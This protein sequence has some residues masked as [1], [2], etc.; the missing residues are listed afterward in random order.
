MAMSVRI[1]AAAS[2]LTLGVTVGACGSADESDTSSDGGQP[3]SESHIPSDLTL[4]GSDYSYTVDAGCGERAGLV[5]MYRIRVVD[6]EVAHVW[7]LSGG[8]GQV[9]LTDV[10]TIDQLVEEAESAE[11]EGADQVTVTTSPQG[12]P[13]RIMIDQIADAIDDEVCYTIS[14]VVREGRKLQVWTKPRPTI[15]WTKQ[16]ELRLTTYGSSSC[17]WVPAA[18]EARGTQSVTIRLEGP[19]RDEICTM[20]LAPHHSTVELPSRIDRRA[21][22]LTFVLL[23]PAH[24]PLVLTVE[25]NPMLR[26]SP[27]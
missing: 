21:D 23:A 2:V 25:Q 18:V 5:G 13:H 11:Q 27:R 24:Q 12:Y 17:P 16:R 22:Q 20:D 15:G 9:A 3:P 6:G 10:P 14:D 19:D 4:P 1:I 26:G 7:L 8:G